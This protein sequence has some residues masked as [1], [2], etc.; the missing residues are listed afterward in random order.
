MR[1]H[2]I[3]ELRWIDV[4][5]LIPYHA[6]MAWNVWGEPN[7]VFFTGN[8]LISSIV[9][10]LSPYYMPLMFLLAGISTRYAL[11]KRTCKQY[12]TERAKRLLVP[13]VF[14]TAVFMPLMTYMADKNSCGYS[15]GFLRHYGVF[16]TKYTDLTGADGGFSLGQFWFLLYL[17]VISLISAGIVSLQKK[18]IALEMPKI[19]FPAI[20]LLGAPLPLLNG[21]LSAGGKSL[22]EYTYIFLVGYYVFSDDEVIEKAAGYLPFTLAVGLSASAADVYLFI[23]SSKDLTVLNTAA[24]YISEWSMLL[25]LMGTGKKYLDRTCMVTDYMSKRSFPFFSFHYIW[26]VMFQYALAGVFE[27]NTVLLYL[28]PVALSYIATLLCCEVC[29][30]IPALSFLMGTKPVTGKDRKV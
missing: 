15:G 19:S 6:A 21:L 4:F 13:L 11:R 2:F 7:Y 14:G 12:V 25:A 18:H 17:F 5:L 3:D 30:R 29:L 9:V 20:C 27:N 8:K 1:K 26:L 10:F 22:A 24:K 23:W 16:F 28:V